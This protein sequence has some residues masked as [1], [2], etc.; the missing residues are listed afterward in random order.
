[1]DR[2]A[3]SLPLQGIRVLDFSRLLPGPWCT[4]MLADLGADVIKVEQPGI[5]DPARHNPPDYRTLSV[6]FC[7]V[8]RGKRSIALDL[9]S[10][11][12][13]EVALR[14][15]DRA[16]VLIE[17]FRRGVTT[18]LGID[19]EAARARNARLIY[20]SITGFGQDGP[21]AAV[22]GHDLV[23][24]AMTGLMNVQPVAD[25]IPPVPGFQA[26]DYA[27]ATSALSGI[28]AA[29]LRRDRTGEAAMLDI[30]MF[31]SLLAMGNV[32]LTGAMARAA[33]SPAVPGMEVWGRN[34]RYCTYRTRD[35]K[36]VAVSLLE[37]RT[38]QHFCRH[39][40][41]PDLIAE[42]ESPRDRHS[43]HGDRAALFRD[44]LTAYFAAHDRDGVVAE[45]LDVDVPICPV[46]TP[47]EALAHPH[48]AARGLL[49]R[50]EH[51]SEGGIPRLANPLARSG[52]ARTAEREPPALGADTDAVL[53]ELGY[54]ADER[55]AFHDAGVV[56]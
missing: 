10:N 7:N 6:Y 24:Q 20:C 14:L 46:S 13:R 32:T 2:A 15:I 17:S 22:P 33:G 26:A 37:T 31:D 28:L 53:A 39:I 44:T 43:T 55:V 21:L 45:L 23:I 41:R 4:Q 38:W 25:V 18:R 30:S 51:S 8:N 56:A 48:V 34:P 9:S 54:A 19:A 47:E 49:D 27:G 16:D 5:G 3:A 1:M 52:L 29:L 42:D 11:A 12:G 35:G 40:G 50:I 36:A